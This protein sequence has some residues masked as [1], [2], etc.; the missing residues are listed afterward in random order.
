[1]PTE[2]EKQMLQLLRSVSTGPCK[3]LAWR[4]RHL[5]TGKTHGLKGGTAG[6][7]H[8]AVWLAFNR[9]SHMD[10]QERLVRCWHQLGRDALL[11]VSPN[12]CTP[13]AAPSPA[14]LRPPPAAKQKLNRQYLL[15]P[16]PSFLSSL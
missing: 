8:Q 9:A 14:Q 12:Y 2:G 10:A 5:P 3:D 15:S 13:P 6:S 7:P 4:H 11:P 1:M 16:P